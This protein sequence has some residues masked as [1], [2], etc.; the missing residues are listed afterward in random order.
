[1]RYYL[2]NVSDSSAAF[3][4]VEVVPGT[5]DFDPEP[6]GGGVEFAL[7]TEMQS[8]GSPGA[9][10]ITLVIS[11]ASEVFTTGANYIVNQMETVT[12][13]SVSLG[14]CELGAEQGEP[15]TISTMA[16][17]LKQGLAEG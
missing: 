1:I 14:I 2:R 12:A 6:G 5:T 7:D 15:G 16:Q 4:E 3:K 13:V 17:A 8:V 11:P 9:D 10:S